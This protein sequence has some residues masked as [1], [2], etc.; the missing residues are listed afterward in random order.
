MTN[1]LPTNQPII[2]GAGLAGLIAA[3]NLAPRPVVV[4]TKSALGEN[5]ASCW[6]LGGVAAAVLPGDNIDL[7]VADTLAAG[8]GLCDPDAVRRIV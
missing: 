1:P 3:L 5:A 2:I 8:D 6:A 7:H 4:L